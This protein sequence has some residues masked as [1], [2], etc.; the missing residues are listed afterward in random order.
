MIQ[1]EEH[2]PRKTGKHQDNSFG[3]L[4]KDLSALKFWEGAVLL[5]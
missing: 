4:D 1:P 5:A 3:A 2:R